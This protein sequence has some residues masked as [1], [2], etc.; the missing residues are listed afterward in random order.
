[1]MV[2]AILLCGALALGACASVT[3]GTVQRIHVQVAPW[4][5]TCYGTDPAGAPVGAFNPD[6][7]VYMVD[8]SGDPIQLRCQAPG[9]QPT[10]VTLVPRPGEWS[11]FKDTAFEIGLID[12]LSGALYE[13]DKTAALVL[14]PASPSQPQ[15]PR[16]QLA[17]ALQGLTVYMVE[18]QT[19]RDVVDYY[20]ADG[21][22]V[23]Q[24]NQCEIP[25]R[26]TVRN[27]SQG[28][29]L[30]VTL[31]DASTSTACYGVTGT[32]E[33]LEYHDVAGTDLTPTLVSWRTR[34]DNPEK[35]NWN[36]PRCR[37]QAPF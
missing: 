33:T 4:S 1:M 27:G 17:S 26:W 12:T 3:E 18:P 19:G 5:A 2:R 23:R 22:L 25:G 35:L 13:Y 10:T 8:K 7:H 9:Y 37:A 32:V 36:T 34:P 31:Y 11:L 29:E 21:R 24:D 6:T 16:G 15:P 14:E 20:E 30:C 28:Q